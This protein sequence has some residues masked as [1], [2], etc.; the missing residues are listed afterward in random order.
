MRGSLASLLLLLVFF[1]CGG[2]A[3]KGSDNAGTTDDAGAQNPKDGS[4]TVLDATV[5]DG[6]RPL[7]TVDAGDRPC[8]GDGDCNGGT[9]FEGM[10][11]CEVPK[12]VQPNGRCGDDAPPECTA[13]SGTCRQNPAECMAGELEGELSTNQTCGDFIAAV[14]CYP[15]AS[16]KTTV[17]FVCCGAS[18]TPYEPRCVNGWRTCLGLMPKLRDTKCP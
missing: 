7:P 6:G 3:E 9:C 15:A 2:D 17:D 14:C 8:N 5:V 16:C 13:S 4:S 18:T 12:Y 11:M 1:A 10:C